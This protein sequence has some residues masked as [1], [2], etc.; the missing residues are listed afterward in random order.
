MEI[1]P[2]LGLEVYEHCLLWAILIPRDVSYT[3]VTKM[4]GSRAKKRMDI[5]F[6]TAAVSR[7]GLLNLVGDSILV[8]IVTI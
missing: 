5:G 2:A 3:D 1:M 4:M 6:Y 8:H 7:S